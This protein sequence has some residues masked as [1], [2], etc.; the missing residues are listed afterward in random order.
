MLPNGKTVAS[1]QALRRF[2][3]RV[4][5]SSK[6]FCKD[7]VALDV[8]LQEGIS[9][10]CAYGTAAQ[11]CPELPLYKRHTQRERD[12]LFFLLGRKDGSA[13]K[14]LNCNFGDLANQLDQSAALTTTACV[15]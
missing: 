11:L 13:V 9:R 14:A 3:G 2:L 12:Y 5:K 1:L 6:V 15:T 7:V 8:W 10:H 4:Q